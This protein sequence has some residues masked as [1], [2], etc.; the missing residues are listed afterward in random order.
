M[1]NLLP[2]E[3][4][5]FGFCAKQ[6]LFETRFRYP[7]RERARGLCLGR[8]VAISLFLFLLFLETGTQND[9]QVVQLAPELGG[10][11]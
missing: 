4:E 5:C 3:G 1:D 9:I 8:A 2:R 6:L 10:G 11:E 7:G